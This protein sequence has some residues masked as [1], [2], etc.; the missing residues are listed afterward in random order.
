MVGGDGGRVAG[1]G[2]PVICGGGASCAVKPGGEGVAIGG[3]K[4]G[5]GVALFLGG[6]DWRGRRAC[7]PFALGCEGCEGCPGARGVPPGEAPGLS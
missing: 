7:S 5:A 1:R 6:V 3:E 4:P 2:V